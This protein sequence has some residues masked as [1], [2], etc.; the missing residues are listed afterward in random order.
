MA[1]HPRQR[2]EERYGICEFHPLEIL[3]E[4][5]ADRCIHIKEDIEKYSRIFYVR[6]HNKYLKVVTDYNVSYVKTVLPDTTDFNALEKLINK[7]S[8]CSAMAS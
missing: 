2:A 8:T 6:Y 1:S 7:L 3:K 4:I 5:L